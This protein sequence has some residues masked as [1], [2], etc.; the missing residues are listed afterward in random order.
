MV[1]FGGRQNPH[2]TSDSLIAYKYS[3]NLW[4]RLITKDM[5]V[6]GSPPPPA[7][8]HAMTHADPESNAVYVV[9][10]FDGGIK[11]HVT[12]ISIPEDLCNL[13]IDKTTCRQYFGC[14]FCSVTTISGTNASFCFSNEVSI[15]KTIGTRVHPAQRALNLYP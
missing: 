2:N 1:I 4:I 6:I 5:E 13:W 14:S 15:N 9:G 11:S 8:A 3:C 10:G 7:Y 12:L